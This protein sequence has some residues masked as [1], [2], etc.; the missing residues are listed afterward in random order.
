VK[1]NIVAICVA[2]ITMAAVVTSGKISPNQMREETRKMASDTLVELYNLEPASQSIIQKSA[3]YAV[4]DSK[5]ADFLVVRTARGSGV[6]INSRT[7]QETFMKMT[8]AGAG[9]GLRVN[10]YRVVFRFE[11]PRALSQ[12]VNSGWDSSGQPDAIAKAKES[13]AANSGAANVAPGVWVYQITTN[14]L[15]PQLSLH[16]TKYFK[17]DDLNKKKPRTELTGFAD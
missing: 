12:F 1:R 7:S 11:T 10:D 6:A 2:A 4:F 17:D 8:S 14:G 16:G 13:G 9:L 3:G 15:A 5:G